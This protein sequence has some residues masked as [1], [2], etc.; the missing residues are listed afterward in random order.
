MAQF[1]SE[2]KTALIEMK[3]CGRIDPIAIGSFVHQKIGEIHP[4]LD[5]NGRLSRAFLN[6][7]LME[8]GVEPVVFTNDEEYTKAVEKDN[9]IPG[10]FSKY[11]KE[12]ILPRLRD[13]REYLN[14]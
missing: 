8:Y 13:L 6:A 12:T 11:L 2:L 5:G 10:H 4:F 9:Q 14:Q 1:A 7:I 3:K